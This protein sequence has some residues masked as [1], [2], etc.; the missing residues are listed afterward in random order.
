[1]LLLIFHK[2]L[3]EK[4]YRLLCLAYKPVKSTDD[5][6]SKD[7]NNVYSIE[8]NDFLLLGLIAMKDKI[9]IKVKSA[10]ERCQKA[11]IK[12]RMV[13][14]DNK[15]TAIRYAKEAGIF[16]EKSVALDGNEL[17]ALT[18]G[19]VC[20]NCRIHECPCERDLE[21]AIRDK[22]SYRIDV[23]AN[24]KEFDRIINY[25]DVVSRASPEDKYAMVVGLKQKGGVVA[26]TGDGANDASAMKAANVAFAMGENGTEIARDASSIVLMD[27][28][29]ETLV[30]AVI[31]GRNI[32]QAVRKFLQFQLTVNFSLTILTIIGASVMKQPV[33]TA[34]QML[35]VNLIMDSLASLMLATDEPEE[36]L[37][38]KKSEGKNCKIITL[39]MWKHIIFQVIYQLI[40]MNI[41]VYYGQNFI[42]EEVDEIDRRPNFIMDIKYN[43]GIYEIKEGYY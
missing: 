3:T 9:R 41:F 23:I 28:D 34:V 20:S 7:S 15:K 6:Q 18:G 19:L 14:G 37:L 30:K 10:I 21:H 43:T 32:G 29:F 36:G 16:N 4:G 42:W 26:V 27:D 5:F 24:R 39:K 2:E 31:W 22:T 33:L 35:W 8:N 11:G 1:V 40:I 38:E 25:L 17:M 12:V 13:T